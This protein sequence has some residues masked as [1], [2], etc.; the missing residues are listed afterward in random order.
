MFSLRAAGLASTAQS[1]SMPMPRRPAERTDQGVSRQ[2]VCHRDFAANQPLVW[3]SIMNAEDL[4]A[5]QSPIK[6]RYRADPEAA[7]VTLRA[8]VYQTLA[9][10]PTLA[11][12]CKR[13]SD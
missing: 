1:S 5:V 12:S 10:P 9:H 8:V 11:V 2:F 3:S 7:L 4:R 13:G 6:E